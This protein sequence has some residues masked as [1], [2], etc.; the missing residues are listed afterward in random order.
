[1]WYAGIDWA[2][3]HHDTQVIDEAG[4]QIASKRVAHTKAGVETL[5]SFLNAIPGLQHKDQLACI[6][7][8]SRGLLITSLLEAGFTVYPVHPKTVDR[9]RGAAG[10]KTDQVD[11]YLLAKLGRSELADLRQL[12]PDAPLIAELK[13]LTRDQQGL[14]Q[15]QTRLINQIKAC[16]K[17]YYPAALHLFSHIQQPITLLF[18]QAYPTPQ[19]AMAATVEQLT[20]LL[21]QGK[22]PQASKAA[23]RIFAHLHEPQLQASEVTT[24]TKSRLLLALVQQLQPLIQQIADYEEVIADLFLS[25][26]DRAIF[27]S[28]PGA[29]ARL[30]PR[31]LAEVGDDRT[32]YADAQGLS[33]LAGTAPVLYQSGNYRKAHRRHACLKHLRNALYQFAWQSTHSQA[34]A[35]AY[36]QRKRQEGKSHSVAVRALSHVWVRI[37]YAMWITRTPYDPS[38]FEAARQAHAPRAA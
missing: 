19:E 10:T 9:R 18:L 22:H 31:L 29:G 35:S 6:I 4:R 25:H 1:M 5:I 12:Q 17:A 38:I 7:E 8:T 14:I 34:W 26:A 30:A 13:D 15:M 37:L 36:Y 32:R 33:A 3:T 28:L 11:A 16:L 27:E 21:K 24:R 20:R 23:H 2:D